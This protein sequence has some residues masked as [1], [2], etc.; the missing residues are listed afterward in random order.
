M[1]YHNPKRQREVFSSTAETQ[2]RNPSL[3]L[4]VG[5]VANKQ[6][7]NWR[8]ELVNW[9]T[10]SRWP[11]GNLFPRSRRELLLRCVGFECGLA[12]ASTEIAEG[13]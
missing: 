8:F 6:P 5:I 3:T 13:F 2:K 10:K 1:I 9:I 4:R 12:L 7:E 11:R